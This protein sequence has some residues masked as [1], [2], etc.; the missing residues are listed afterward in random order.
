[1]PKLTLYD[2]APDALQVSV[3]F[4]ATPVAPLTGVGADGVAGAAAVVDHQT[5]PVLV[6]GAVAR[7]DAPEVVV[8][9]AVV[10]G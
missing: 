6:P 7:D 10:V 2:V 3:A 1:M 4:V 9:A 5:G 8:L